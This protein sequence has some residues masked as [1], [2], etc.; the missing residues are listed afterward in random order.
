[1]G[2]WRLQRTG[3]L[4]RRG[5]PVISTNLMTGLT[6]E[7][8]LVAP[9]GGL[10]RGSFRIGRVRKFGEYPPKISF[11]LVLI[12]GERPAFR[13]A[14]EIFTAIVLTEM[15]EGGLADRQGGFEVGGRAGCQ[16][17]HPCRIA[18]ISSSGQQHCRARDQNS[19]VAWLQGDRTVHVDHRG[20]RQGLGAGT[21][22]SSERLA[23]LPVAGSPRHTRASA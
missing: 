15:V 13:E 11:G 12:A 10:C 2:R 7:R 19:D 6:V 17:S 18:L 20:G 21:V 4:F 8:A 1:V 5:R 23:G 3:V 9:I 14:G 16:I 22:A